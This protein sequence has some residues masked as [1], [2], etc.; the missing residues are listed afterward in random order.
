M[1]PA[2]V[3]V[4]SQLLKEATSHD[5]GFDFCG[6]IKDCNCC[7]PFHLDWTKER[8]EADVQ[9][10]TLPT[11]YTTA[12]ISFAAAG[13]FDNQD[14][15]NVACELIWQQ[16]LKDMTTTSLYTQIWEPEKWGTGFVLIVSSILLSVFAK[17]A[18]EFSNL[19]VVWLGSATEC[20][21]RSG[22]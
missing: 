19:L 4:A 21:Q 9:W 14:S 10:S 3:F 17:D 16:N 22:K 12:F 6:Y 8:I 1:K 13:S 2:V 11:N 20:K 5:D 18:L 7:Q 15:R